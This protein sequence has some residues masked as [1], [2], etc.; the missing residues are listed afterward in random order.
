MDF[1][2]SLLGIPGSSNL[3]SCSLL[4]EVDGD[5]RFPPSLASASR[6]QSL[7]SHLCAGPAPFFRPSRSVLLGAPAAS[8][9][10]GSHHHLS[11]QTVLR[12]GVGVPCSCAHRAP[13]S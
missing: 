3:G 4:V 7:G 11:P 12:S 5:L 10:P 13:P 8:V 6:S 2:F 1:N 9:L